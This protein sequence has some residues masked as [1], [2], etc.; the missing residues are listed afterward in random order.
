MYLF[1]IAATEKRLLTHWPKHYKRFVCILNGSVSG[2]KVVIFNIVAFR[3]V[4]ALSTE[5]TLLLYKYIP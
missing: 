4:P 5:S 3:I 2:Q 1:P